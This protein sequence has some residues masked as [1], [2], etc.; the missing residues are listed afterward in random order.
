MRALDRKLLRD[1]RLMWSQ[2]LTIALVVASGIGGFI[3]TLSA[4]DSLALARDRFYAQGH[5]ADVF[6]SVKRAPDAQAALLREIRG[7][8]D[9]QTTTEMLVRIE[10]P[11]ASDPIVGQLIGVDRLHPPQ[12]NLV[13]LRRG[14]TL[15]TTG[16]A[17]SAGVIDALVSEA[18]ANSHRL[19][20]GSTLG[21]LVN[22]KQRTLRIAGI[23][24]SPEFIF[25]GLWG[26]PDQR[27]FGVFWVDREALAAAYD[28]AGSFN[29]VAVKLAPGAS[30][31]DVIDSVALQLTRWGGREAYGRKNQISHSMLDNEI[32]EQYVMGTVLPSIF[33]G[34]AA[35]LLNVVVSRL[36]ATQREQIA[37]LKAVGYANRAIAV[38]Y[39]KLVLLIVAIGLVLG[40]WLGN[41][42][43]AMF[44]GLYAEFFRFPSFE[45][46]IAPWLLAVSLG[47]TLL[48]AV[49]GNTERHCSH[50]A[51]DT[52]RGHAPAFTRAL[53]PQHGRTPAGHPLKPGA[54]HD[55]AQYGKAPRADDHV[56]HGCSGCSGHRGDGQLLS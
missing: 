23:A 34:V 36:V 17:R 40:V 33:L 24:L 4:T 25:A 3:T 47:L 42:L 48:T 52:S 8:A 55:L 32:K 2:V 18:F 6:A 51:P 29:R 27:S 50:R 35:F 46:V 21:A 9:V 49:A 15:D 7:V 14:Q 28:M 31:P 39:L 10:M 37:T 54:A 53:P 22:G 13:T 45:H 44:T 41:V 26:M 38:H 5:F 11:G 12:L 56:H 43:G 30:E 1:L 16:H 19:A 20:P